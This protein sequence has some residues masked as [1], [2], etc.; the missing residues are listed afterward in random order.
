[1]ERKDWGNLIK[2]EFFFEKFGFEHHLKSWTYMSYNKNSFSNDSAKKNFQNFSNFCSFRIQLI[3][4]IFQLIKMWRRKTNFFF[5][6]KSRVPS[7][8]ARSLLINWACFQVKFD[9]CPIPLNRSNFDFQK[10][11]G[12]RYNFFKHSFCLSL[13][14]LSQSLLSFFFFFLFFWSFSWS[15]I[16]RFSSY[17]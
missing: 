15:K 5:N 13:R 12:I 10:H 1:M 4:S 2:F 7:I 14:F 3:K 8:L 9:S 6:S 17:T 16:Q 11:I